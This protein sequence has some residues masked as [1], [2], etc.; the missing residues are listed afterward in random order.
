MITTT[1]VPTLTIARLTFGIA[2]VNTV[3]KEHLFSLVR[4]FGIK[5]TPDA[6]SEIASDIITG[7]SH[8]KITEIML[9]LK[10]MREGKFREGFDGSGNRAEMF[11]VLSSA[12]ICDCI[13]RFCHDYRNP[14]L[15]KKMREKA[16]KMRL[17]AN[18]KAATPS[19]KLNI[20]G[21]AIIE[22][23]DSMKLLSQ[24]L[25][26]E[27]RMTLE[28]YARERQALL[29]LKQRVEEYINTPEEQRNTATLEK[30]IEYI[31]SEFPLD[32]QFIEKINGTTP[33]QQQ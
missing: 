11:G 10:M 9:A 5:T 12:V 3:V 14:I 19:E 13:N 24:F 8:L 30:G 4:A 33:K 6:V 2:V 26:K 23:P 21:G 18:S 25:T 7:Y 22:S 15:D 27:Q 16:L 31:N 29:R 32:P 28:Y 1:S 20:I 17:E